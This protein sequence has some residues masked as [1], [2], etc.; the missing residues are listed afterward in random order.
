[1]TETQTYTH[2]QKHSTANNSTQLCT[3][4]VPEQPAA[5]PIAARQNETE[6]TEK[7]WYGQTA[8]GN[9]QPSDYDH[10]YRNDIRQG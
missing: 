9:G 3:L 7:T 8:A 10:N 1:M 6:N 4:N 5:G 2:Q